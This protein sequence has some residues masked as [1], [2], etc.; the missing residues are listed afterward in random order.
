MKRTGRSG[1]AA[2]AVAVNG[3][4]ADAAPISSARRRM[5]CGVDLWLM[6]FSLFMFL[7][8]I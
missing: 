8:S 2:C 7:E 4:A 5:V 3:S 1:H 6:G